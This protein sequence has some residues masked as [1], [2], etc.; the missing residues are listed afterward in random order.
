MLSV[1]D[2]VQRDRESTLE[3]LW[4][5]FQATL[6]EYINSTEDKQNQ[7]ATLKAQDE[8]SSKSILKHCKMLTYFYVN[9]NVCTI[10]KFYI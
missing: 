1:I 9:V 4:K 10:D 6:Q 5:E 7:Y 2:W 8:L 3:K